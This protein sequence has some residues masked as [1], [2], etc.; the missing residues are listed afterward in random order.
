MQFTTIFT[1]IGKFNVFL[2]QIDK[3]SYQ[4]SAE[5]DAYDCT[6]ARPAE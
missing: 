5:E 6:I 3:G 4:G 2:L 1:I